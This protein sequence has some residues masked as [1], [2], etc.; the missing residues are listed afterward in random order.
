MAVTDLWAP[1][2]RLDIWADAIVDEEGAKHVK[3]L[4][5][6]RMESRMT[7]PVPNIPFWRNFQ[8]CCIVHGLVKE[9]FIM[10]EQRDSN[11]L[12]TIGD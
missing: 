6:F 12:R 11:H 10:T 9:K 8:L 1:L 2:V 3:S 4:H 7:M 5:C